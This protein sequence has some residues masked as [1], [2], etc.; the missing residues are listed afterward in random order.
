MLC[1]L[2]SPEVSVTKLPSLTLIIGILLPIVTYVVA[3]SSVLSPT[4][5]YWKTDTI[6]DPL[7]SGMERVSSVQGEGGVAEKH[8]RE[9]PPWSPMNCTDMNSSLNWKT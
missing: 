5:S 8:D 2:L 6:H 1:L 7:F 4:V 3:G 9:I